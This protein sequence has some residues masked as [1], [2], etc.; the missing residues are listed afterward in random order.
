MRQSR[1]FRAA[2]VSKEAQLEDLAQPRGFSG[3][4]GADILR[5]AE[6]ARLRHEHDVQGL[7]VTARLKHDA[8]EE[9][10]REMERGE[11]AHLYGNPSHEYYS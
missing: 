10:L 6:D 2:D 11:R 4:T 9:Q 1:D 7:D 3:T 5:E 8:M